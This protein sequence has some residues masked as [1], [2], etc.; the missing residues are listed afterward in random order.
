M[1]YTPGPWR[2]I[3]ADWTGSEDELP[4]SG[5]VHPLVRFYVE[6]N[7]PEIRASNGYLIS[8]AL[9]LLDAAKLTVQNFERTR[10]SGNFLGDDD[11]EAWLALTKAIA[12]AEGK[13]P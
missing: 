11:H 4:V 8:A 13:E 6:L 7:P 2:V 5:A 10:A 1:D 12:K 3:A 9:D